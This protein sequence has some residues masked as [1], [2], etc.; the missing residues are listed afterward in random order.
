[1]AAAGNELVQLALA[2]DA[3]FELVSIHPFYDGNGWTS[4]LLMNF[5]QQ[6]FGLPL[7][8]VFSEDKAEYFDALE[9]ARDKE[10]QAIFRKF[11]FGQFEK[12]LEQEIQKFKH[13]SPLRH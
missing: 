11:M 7:T 10:D 1:M 2:F 8:I 4:R 12:Q 9:A 5:I 3:H 6:Y 13:I